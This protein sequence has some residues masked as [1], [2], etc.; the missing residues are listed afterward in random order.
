LLSRIP[1]LAHIFQHNSILPQIIF[2]FHASFTVLVSALRT[3]LPADRPVHLER[4]AL[5]AIPTECEFS[6]GPPSLLRRKNP[7]M[8]F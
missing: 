3:N 1:W 8:I 2:A 4:P 7:R 6:L 5:G